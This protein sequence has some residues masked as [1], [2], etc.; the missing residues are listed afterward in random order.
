MYSIYIALTCHSLCFP[1][2]SLLS[3]VRSVLSLGASKVYYLIFPCFNQ[4][5]FCYGISVSKL[6]SLQL[7]YGNDVLSN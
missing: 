3:A 2:P 7:L 1:P 6:F 5:K 4:K